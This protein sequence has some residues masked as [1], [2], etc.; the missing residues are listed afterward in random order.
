MAVPV[1]ATVAS[2]SSIDI[3]V[4]RHA[5]DPD[6]PGLPEI[7][8]AAA[9]AHGV[10]TVVSGKIRYTPFA[11]YVGADQFGYTLDNAG[12]RSSSVVQLSVLD[13]GSE[14]PPHCGRSR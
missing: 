8:A 1:T 5:Y 14:L 2:G 4:A 13:T 9:P 6:G 7:V 11:G 12:K 3:D 10:V